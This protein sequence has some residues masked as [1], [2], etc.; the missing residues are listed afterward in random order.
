MSGTECRACHIVCTQ[1][2]ENSVYPMISIHMN[3][4]LII[5]A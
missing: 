3:C 4:F 2:I 1:Y 5:S